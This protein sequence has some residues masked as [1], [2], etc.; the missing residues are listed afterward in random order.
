M[1]KHD[2]KLDI[3]DKLNVMLLETFSLHP[4]KIILHT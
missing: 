3:E 2:L 4:T 1:V